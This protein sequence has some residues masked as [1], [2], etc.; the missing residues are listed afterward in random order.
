MIEQKKILLPFKAEDFALAEL[1]QATRD[2]DQQVSQR[3]I[4]AIQGLPAG[5]KLEA[6]QVSR[7]R[8]DHLLTASS[9][10][11]N[12]RATFYRTYTARLDD[13]LRLAN[14]IISTATRPGSS[15]RHVD[16]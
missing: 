15:E 12:R 16:D 10:Q 5:G 2:Y 14:E 9:T 7:E 13:M 11:A 1:H 4:S 6:I 8:L 3:V